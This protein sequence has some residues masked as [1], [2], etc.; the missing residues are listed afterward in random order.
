LHKATAKFVVA[1]AGVPTPSFHL[2]EKESDIDA[3][4]CNKPLFVKPVSEGTGKGITDRN[5]VSGHK[6]VGARI[7]E[8]LADY[9]QAVLVEEY[10]PG[11]EFTVG[12]LGTGER[13]RAIGALELIPN[14]NAEANA[15]TYLNKEE[16]ETRVGYV[17]AEGRPA[18]ESC[19]VA[20]RAWKALGCRDAG[21]VDVRADAEGK[22]QF[23][24][25]NPLAGLHPHHSDL[26]ILCT[27][28]GIAYEI[29]IGTIVEEA[30]YRIEKRESK[31]VP[32]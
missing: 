8:L 10:L 25:V 26:P 18:E 17:F 4:N 23:I 30:S 7:R 32:V 6:E 2:I 11:R 5:L 19:D 1:R 21:R 28:I 20:L 27:K 15:Y 24:E 16:C 14:E 9:R 22:I 31:E 3:V 13:A 29:L 12:I